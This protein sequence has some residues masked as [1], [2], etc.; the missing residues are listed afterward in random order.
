MGVWIVKSSDESQIYFTVD[1]SLVKI[2]EEKLLELAQDIDQMAMPT[3]PDKNVNLFR[4]K[5]DNPATIEWVLNKSQAKGQYIPGQI[6]IH[7]D[8]LV[9]KSRIIA[10]VQGTKRKVTRQLIIPKKVREIKID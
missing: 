7:P 5:S 4:I 10:V 2:S 3:T 6:W 9:I 8:L 1:E